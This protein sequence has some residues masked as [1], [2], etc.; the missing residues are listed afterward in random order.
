MWCFITYAITAFVVYT[1]FYFWSY[2]IVFDDF[3]E[4]TVKTRKTF[5]IMFTS[6]LYGIFWPLLLLYFLFITI[7]NFIKK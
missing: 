3:T 4:R 2:N 6:M 7:L 1:C 5:L